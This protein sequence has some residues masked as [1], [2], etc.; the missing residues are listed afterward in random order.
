MVYLEPHPRY[1][2]YAD[3]H[4]FEISQVQTL[5]FYANTNEVPDYGTAPAGLQQGLWFKNRHI[6]E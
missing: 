5:L 3:S 2:K 4:S 6:N 1:Y